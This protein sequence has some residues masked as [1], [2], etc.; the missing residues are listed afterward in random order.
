MPVVI[1]QQGSP[2]LKVLNNLRPT[3]NTYLNQ[4]QINQVKV[5]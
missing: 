3:M 2:I 5:I 4:T 1:I